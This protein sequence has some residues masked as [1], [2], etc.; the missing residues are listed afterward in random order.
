MNL[1]NVFV[2]VAVV[3]GSLIVRGKAGYENGYLK[4]KIP[5]SGTSDNP[6]A[7]VFQTVDESVAV[8]AT[9]LRYAV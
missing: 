5:A 7:G 2:G 8:L 3:Y 4:E 9:N 6:E 1:W